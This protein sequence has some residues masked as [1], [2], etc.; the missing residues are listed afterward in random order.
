MDTGVRRIF[1]LR[2]TTYPRKIES[3]VVKDE[4]DIRRGERKGEVVSQNEAAVIVEK[5]II[6][7]NYQNFI[8]D[9]SAKAESHF[10]I[11]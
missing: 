1:S 6:I 7:E 5:Q 3:N 11:M 4:R 8:E 2:A 10:K 9:N